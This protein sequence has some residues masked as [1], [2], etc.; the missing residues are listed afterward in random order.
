VG[1]EVLD[2]EHRAGDAFKGIEHLA[3]VA[4][5]KEKVLTKP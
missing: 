5:L 4:E 1:V 2:D 3:E